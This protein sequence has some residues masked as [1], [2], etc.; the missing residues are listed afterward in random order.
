MG[1]TEYIMNKMIK[2]QDIVPPWIEKQQELL[3]AANVFRA[4]LRNDWRRHAA[5]MIASRGGS[6][7]EQMA[8]AEEYARA[9]KVH[10]PRRKPVNEISVP[11]N[12]TEDAV[13][14]SI[15]QQPY[16]PGESKGETQYAAGE[17]GTQE[18]NTQPVLTRPFR[19]PTWEATEKS[20]MD[21]AISNLN[22]ITRSY[23]LMAPELA[24]KPY[25][26][27]QREL[28]SCFAEIAP[29][30]ANE[31]KVRATKPPEH[32]IEPLSRARGTLEL[33]GSKAQ[34]SAKVYDSKAPHYGLKE[35][36]RD[37]WSK[38]K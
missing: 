3:K 20:Y 18:A 38:P 12:T 8:R 9:E 27:L 25:F 5:R 35:F 32:L 14:V 34:G 16:M 28:D 7:Q 13:M 22:A 11:T 15:R 26:S 33:F 19:D 6:L 10:N 24:K 23:N 29:E 2:R 21:L 37:L 4:R 36:W 30:L 31:I 1:Q 17:K